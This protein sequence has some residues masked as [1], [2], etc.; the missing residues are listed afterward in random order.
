MKS[1]KRYSKEFKKEAVRLVMESDRPTEQVA[2]ELGI[3][4]DMLRRW[5]REQERD[6]EDAF[7]G[8]GRLKTE[9]EEVRQLKR[10]LA[11][12]REERDILKKAVVIFSDRKS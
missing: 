10:E 5:K 6:E 8:S 2:R 3:R 9:E 12:V 1:R 7:R 4:S 11:R